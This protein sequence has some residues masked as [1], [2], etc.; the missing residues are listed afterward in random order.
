M[1][2][3]TSDDEGMLRL[4]TVGRRPGAEHF[5]ILGYFEEGSDLATMAM[6][7]LGEPEPAWWLNLQAK[8][9]T[10]VDLVDGP[11]TVRARAAGGGERDRQWARW[12][13]YNKN[14]DQYAAL[15]S[16]DTAVVIPA[17]HPSHPS[18]ARPMFSNS[19]TLAG[20]DGTPICAPNL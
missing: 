16:R 15:R 7:G 11:R 6:N 20:G 19:K 17:S 4:R 5:A 8:S 2:R 3:P 18:T 1:R 10:M 14:F 9:D 13:N 12:T